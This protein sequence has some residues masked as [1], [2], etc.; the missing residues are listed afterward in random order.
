[1]LY[2]NKSYTEL[3]LNI[4]FVP[5]TKH[6]Q[7]RLLQDRQ[8]TLSITL[9]RVRETTVAGEKQKVLHVLSLCL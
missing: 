7:S 4:Q 2:R 1:M 3:C 6:S 8:G 9:K 5:R